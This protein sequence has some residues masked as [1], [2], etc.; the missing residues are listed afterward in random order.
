MSI[1][2]KLILG[3]TL[4]FVGVI[5]N[6]L[7][8][9]VTISNVYKLSE[10][11]A[12]ESIPRA[13]DAT[14]AKYQVSQVQQFLTD[15]SLTQ[16]QD[17]VKEAQEANDAFMKD[18]GRF[19]AMFQKENNNKSLSMVRVS[20]NDMQE[21]FIVGKK[22]M[23]SY[24]VSKADGD[25]VMEDFDAASAKLMSKVDEIKKAQVAEA[26]SN[27]EQTMEK[28]NFTK[29]FSL[30]IGIA[31]IM[32]GLLV[33]YLLSNNIL[34]SIKKLGDVIEV[35]AQNHDFTQ[36]VKFEGNDELSQ[37][38]EKINHLVTVL[39]ESFC[40]IGSTSHENLSVA[41][42]LSATTHS[43]GKAAEHEA[44]IVSETTSESLLTKDAIIASASKAQNVKIKALQA[45]ESLQEAQNTLSETNSEL[46]LTVEMESEMNAKLH[47][48]SQEA[49]QVKQVLTVISD[50]ADQT[51]LLALNAA[52]EAARAGEHGRGFA[53]VA[54]EVRKLAER[55][56][57]SL[58]ETNATVNVIV[59]SIMEITEQI[60]TNTQRIENLAEASEQAGHNTQMAVSS[61]SQAVENIEEL[62]TDSQMNASAIEK[63]IMK[64]ENIRTYSTSNAKNVE[65]I[66][67]AAE[68]LHMMTQN[69]STKIS[70]YRT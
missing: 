63:I 55:T 26:I 36:N 47:S 66:A 12:H 18:M 14:D 57:K 19:E 60:T 17:S 56:Q 62:A 16:N 53:V 50:I 11:A 46:I 52:I 51:N 43:I 68:H 10:S 15:A 38:G 3:L 27:S 44:Q 48:L 59:Q 37:M 28:A 25:K 41:T 1:K 29:Y 21:L 23:A 39:R 30:M 69:L 13:L 67:G 35:V 65:E 34:M 61:L 64:I 24:G 4:I 22:M 8:G 31:T 70:I 9:S 20:K 32:M 54:D 49:S 2:Q 45:R 6:I 33:G 42:Q 7:V 58:V 40:E 5:V